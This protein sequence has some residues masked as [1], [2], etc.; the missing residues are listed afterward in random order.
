MRFGWSLLAILAGGV[1]ATELLMRPTWAE[2]RVL[3][4]LY[5]GAI[6]ATLLAGLIIRWL[7]PRAKSIRIAVFVAS[8]A[9]VAVAAVAVG[10]SSGFMFSSP[11]D[12]RLLGIAL[13]LGVALALAL[14]V[15]L[16]RQVTGDLEKL[17]GVARRVGAGDRNMSVDVDRADEIGVVAS[18]MDLMVEELRTAEEEAAAAA[19]ARR[20]F[21]AA[22]SH[23]LR[24]P[25][26]SLT[27]AVEA[28]QDGVA[29]D[30][31]RFYKVM[32]MDISLLAGLVD[33][34]FLMTRL[35]AGDVSLEEIR[36]DLA[37]VADDAVEA[38]T[39]LAAKSSVRLEL[40][41]SSA[42]PAVGD[43]SALSRVIRNLLDNGIRHAPADS[44]VSVVVE[45]G[46]DARVRVQDTGPGFSEEFITDAFES[47][48]QGDP[49]RSK[50]GGGAGLGLAIA[51]R[52]VEAH[53]GEIWAAPGPGGTVGFV[54]PI[55]AH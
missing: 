38:M 21:L 30:P 15:T 2:R 37:E 42:V 8:T 55:P 43:P 3:V 25:L 52:L 32:G 28:L 20:H 1:L 34:L 44:T 5:V 10:L 41:A 9:A 19:Q 23:D 22:I 54:L 49:S 6:A 46:E 35:E 17:A 53:G 24:T 51:K 11:H 27:A 18:A 36:L 31:E 16:A 14:S 40:Q 13:S 29:E 48:T 33:N 7:V 45:E 12:L 4:S 26:A 39:P 50:A 47:F